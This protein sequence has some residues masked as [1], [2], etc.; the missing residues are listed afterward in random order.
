MRIACAALEIP[1]TPVHFPLAV[2]AQLR[3]GVDAFDVSP[4]GERVVV[5]GKDGAV[6][7]VELRSGKAV[8]LRGHVGDVRDVAF[9]S[10]RSNGQ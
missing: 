9:V 4:N 7:V 5:G 2:P 6:R 10:T 8:E 1:A 3:G